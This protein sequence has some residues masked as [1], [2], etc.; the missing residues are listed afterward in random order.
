MAI[1]AEQNSTPRELIEPGLHVARCYKMIEVGTVQE[2]MVINGRKE[3]K[4][5]KKVRI[6]WE[7]PEMLK[8][9]DEKKGPQ[10]LVI[11][12]EYTLSMGSKANIRKMME[13]WR[14]KPYTDQEAVKVDIT[15]MLTQPCMIN[16]THKQA[17]SGKVYEQISSVVQ[18]PKSMVCPPQVNPTFN[19]SYDT[20]NQ[21][22]F[23]GLP[24][25]IKNKMQTSLEYKKMF[26]NTPDTLSNMGSSVGDVE[27]D[28]LPF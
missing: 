14:G 25:F 3:V 28:D 10:P 16:L 18:M 26:N 8:V 5:L 11:D 2:E 6:G 1:Y 21:D 17:T 4:T 7:F 13:S 24:E 22:M 20:W 9:F 19:L 15:K 12:N 27:D 23:D